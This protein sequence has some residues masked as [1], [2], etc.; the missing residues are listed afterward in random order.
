MTLRTAAQ[1]QAE[2][3]VLEVAQALLV[4]LLLGVVG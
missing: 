2:I 4:A 1:L 3:Q